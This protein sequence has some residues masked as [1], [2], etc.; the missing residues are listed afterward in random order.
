MACFSSTVH[1]QTSDDGE[2]PTNPI[3]FPF[4]EPWN[5]DLFLSGKIFSSGSFDIKRMR[6]TWLIPVLQRCFLSLT[7]SSEITTVTSLTSM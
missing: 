2:R 7:E 3:T 5:F 1:F 4:V 6:M